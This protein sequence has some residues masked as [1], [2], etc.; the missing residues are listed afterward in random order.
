MNILN[1]FAFYSIRGWAIINLLGLGTQMVSGQWC[2][3][4]Y[5][6]EPTNITC[7]YE[8]SAEN[9]LFVAGQ[10]F[11]H[12]GS[13]SMQSVI[14]RYK[15]Q[16]WDTLARMD[17]PAQTVIVHRDTLIV[18]GQF[19]MIN[20]SA[21]H[22]IAYY[23]AGVW[24]PYG[25]FDQTIRR[26]VELNG[27]LYAAGGF[28]VCDS[29]AATGVAKKTSSGWINV[30]IIPV[31]SPPLVFDLAQYN[32]KIIA[33]GIIRCQ[34]YKDLVQFDG[35]EW[36]PVGTSGI[37]GG[38]SGGYTL[39]VFG[40]DLIVGGTIDITA[41][42][43]GHAIMGW[44][45]SEFFSLGIGPQYLQGAYTY[46]YR[47]NALVV[48]HGKLYAGG[49]FNYADLVP[50]SRMAAWDGIGW[51]GLG[52][53]IDGE[54]R[55]LGIYRDTL[56]AATWSAQTFIGEDMNNVAAYTGGADVDTCG[57]SL[58]VTTASNLDALRVSPN[59]ASTSIRISGADVLGGDL[60]IRSMDGRLVMIIPMRRDEQEY[61]ISGLA[62]QSYIITF[63]QDGT[64]KQVSKLLVVDP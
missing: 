44:N 61:D 22:R 34:G 26:L 54:V 17:A 51:C 25:F 42:N 58:G 47:V 3:L 43:A 45:G 62:S 23:D 56:I 29:H 20:D 48:H 63:I 16:V 36:G 40:D 12:F 21:V 38:F 30:G 4:G 55:A 46:L 31:Q 19:T 59:P 8:Y 24:K 53:V 32:G 60:E 50:A 52:G 39:A 64:R 1:I 2:T 6:L 49:G 27:T 33:T 37:V 14:M 28:T 18:A 35:S 41:G 9:E 13:D 57:T 15:D 5:P 7:L 10:Q 11:I